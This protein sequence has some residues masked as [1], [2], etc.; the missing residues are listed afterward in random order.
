ME[1]IATEISDGA[2]TKNG[3]I[4]SS[5]CHPGHVVMNASRADPVAAGFGNNLEF[6]LNHG[7]GCPSTMSEI[8][9]VLQVVSCRLL[10]G[11]AY[12]GCNYCGGSADGGG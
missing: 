3:T 2:S 12:E 9:Q 5:T 8:T 4:G 7:I 1:R 6:R 11:E 10:L